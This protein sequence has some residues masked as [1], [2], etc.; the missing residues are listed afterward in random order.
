MV[1]R[2]AQFIIPTHRNQ[3]TS[4]FRTVQYKHRHRMSSPKTSR[5]EYWS[6][7][8][9][10]LEFG[11]AASITSLGSYTCSVYPDWTAVRFT[12]AT[13]SP[14]VNLANIQGAVL[15]L[16]LL[17]V[18]VCGMRYH[19]N[20]PHQLVTLLLDIVNWCLLLALWISLA[21]QI[22]KDSSNCSVPTGGH[23]QTRPCQT[24]YTCCALAVSSW[25]L[26]TISVGH[27]FRRFRRRK[28]IKPGVGNGTS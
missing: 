22:S 1:T 25:V 21:Y 20:H 18:F 4:T 7:G 8:L 9:R 27:S 26:Y 15:I 10:V 17:Y 6:L 11:F 28:D 23:S 19:P 5:L 13:V 14:Q 2:P 16:S 24:F 3:N 12:V